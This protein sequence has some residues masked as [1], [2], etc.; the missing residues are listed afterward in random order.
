VTKGR[1]GLLLNIER[2]GQRTFVILPPP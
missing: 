1:K 2:K